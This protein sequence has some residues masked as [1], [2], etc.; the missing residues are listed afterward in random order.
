M[1]NTHNRFHPLAAWVRAGKW[2]N[3]EGLFFLKRKRGA[4]VNP[5]KEQQ[6]KTMGQ[7]I[8]KC[9]TDEGFKRKLLADPAATLKAEGVELPAG[10]SIKAVENTDKVFHL[11]IPARPAG[12]ADLSDAELDKVAAGWFAFHATSDAID[13]VAKALATMAQKQ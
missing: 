1:P 10:L 9:W 7:V 6:G 2:G 11:V 8:A 13:A 12:S 5:N 4:T 3:I